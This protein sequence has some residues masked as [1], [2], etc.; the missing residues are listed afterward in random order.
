MQGSICLAALQ[1]YYPGLPS[2]KA[3]LLAQIWDAVVDR[4]ITRMLELSSDHLVTLHVNIKAEMAEELGRLILYLSEQV[5]AKRVGEHDPATI[6]LELE[7]AECLEGDGVEAIENTA[8]NLATRVWIKKYDE[9]WGPKS[10]AALA[11]EANPK[12][13]QL[14]VKPVGDNHFVPRWFVKQY[15]ARDARLRR[16]RK[17]ADGTWVTGYVGSGGWAYRKHLYSDEREAYFQ[18]VEGDAKR[19]IKKL[20]ETSPLTPPEQEALMGYFVIQSM[21]F[22]FFIEGMSR[23]VQA[24]VPDDYRNWAA[25]EE[26]KTILLYDALFENN[27]LYSKIANPLFWSEWALVKSS[28]P[29]F[30]L[31]DT[32]MAQVRLGEESR[33]IVPLTPDTCFVTLPSL[34]HKKRVVPHQL[35]A[36]DDLAREI[37]RLLVASAKSEFAVHP[38]Y[39]LDVGEVP[40]GRDLLERISQKVELLR[41]DG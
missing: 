34:E 16:Y 9:R 37:S 6:D 12:T 5:V 13:T 15:W 33:I 21:R 29:V 35:Q 20:L 8:Q 27:A 32:S 10:E 23:G 17:K 19:P 39:I 36:D 18:L 1:R 7:R 3:A 4:V 41:H 24:L 2:D 38:D 28:L 25:P 31:P 40:D 22:P 14:S 30:I 11:K 26:R